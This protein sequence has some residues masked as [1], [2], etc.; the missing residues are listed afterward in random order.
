[1]ST[2]PQETNSLL[3]SGN[4]SISVVVCYLIYTFSISWF[5]WLSIIIANNYFKTLYYGE[6]VFWIL[7]SI[8][9]LGPA[10]SAFI[11]YRK[12]KI[13]FQSKSF[14]RFIFGHSMNRKIGVIFLAFLVWR[15][16]MIWI[17]VGIDKPFSI[18]AI[19]INLP[20][21]IALGGLEELGWRGILQPKLEGLISY[22]PSLLLV[23]IIWSSWHI[24]L[25]FMKGSVQS[26]FPF[27]LFF[28]AGFILTASFTALYKYT[29][30]LFLCV[31]NHAWFNG[32]IGLA[33]F[34][35][36]NGVIH[37]NLN[38]KLV[39]LFIVEFIISIILVLCQDKKLT[40]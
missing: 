23:S 15:L 11:I 24:P 38:G 9:S 37:I 25:W 16:W 19:I 32:C 21:L 20:F 10:I 22:F 6:P 27:W 5:C 1:M 3:K 12:F 4:N 30:N 36:N 2:K 13:E 34:T 26:G 8:G 28:I 39:A 33:L 40:S 35:G 31:V 18:L 29:H 14:I 17:S 7:Y